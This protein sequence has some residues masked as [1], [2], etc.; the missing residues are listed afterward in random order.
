MDAPIEEQINVKK[1]LQGAIMRTVSVD[2]NK[3][4]IPR[5]MEIEENLK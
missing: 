1:L 3:K 2:R 5:K 4:Q